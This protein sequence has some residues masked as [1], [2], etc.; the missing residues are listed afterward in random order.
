MMGRRH[1]FGA[2]M[3]RYK[4]QICATKAR[5]VAIGYVPRRPMVCRGTKISTQVMRTV[6]AIIN[7]LYADVGETALQLPS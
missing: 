6:L 7:S 2:L 1:S 4:S 3:V 5:F